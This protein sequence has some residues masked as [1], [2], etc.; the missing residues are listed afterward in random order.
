M[1]K[2]LSIIIPAYNEEKTIERIVQKVLTAPIPESLI[3][4]IIIVNDGSTDNTLLILKQC[5]NHPSIKV[6]S[7][8][9]GG[10][11]SALK[12][13]LKEARGDIILIQDA[14]LEYDPM[15]YPHLVAPILNG[16]SHVVYGSRFL[17]KI[18]D[19]HWVNRA[20]N[21]VSNWTMLVMW[22]TKITDIN[23][24][25]KVF[26]KEALAG[27]DIKSQN[28]AFETEITTKF[29]KKGLKVLEVPIAYQA[30]SRQEGKKIKWSTA[31]EMYWPIISHRFINSIMVT[32][33]ACLLCSN[34]AHAF[35]F[36]KDQIK[37]FIDTTISSGV[38]LRLEKPRAYLI[39]RANGGSAYTVDSDDGDRHYKKNKLFSVTSKITN[40]IGVNYQNFGAFIRTNF[41]FDPINRYKKSLTPY[42]RLE[43]GQGFDLL[44]AYVE[45]KF[46]PANKALD[47]RLGNQV[48]NWG[49]SFFIPGGLNAINAVD[50]SKLRLPGAEVREALLPSPMISDSYQLTDN[51]SISNFYIF[52]FDRTK[53]DVCGTYFAT[54]DVFCEG[55]SGDSYGGF[56][57]LPE[58]TAGQIIH[59]LPDQRPSNQGQFGTAFR[60]LSP[61]LNDTEF[62]FYFMNYHNHVPVVSAVAGAPGDLPALVAQYIENLQVYG[63]SA[64]TDL[65]GVALQGEY[66]YRP[67]YPMQIDGGEFVAAAQYFPSAQVAAARAPGDIIRGWREMPVNQLQASVTKAFGRDNPFSAQ[68]WLVAGEAAGIYVGHFPDKKDLRFEAPNTD[69]S[70]YNGVGSPKLQTT[71]WADRFSW[72]YVLATSL[73]YEQVIK[74]VNLVPRLAFSHDVMGTTPSPLN[75]FVEDSKGMTMGLNVLYLHVWSV[76]MS[77]TNYFGAAARNALQDRDF[78]SLTVKHWF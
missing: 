9:N 10:K 67:R 33:L 4:E 43:A 28:F 68:E 25:Y 27:I 5:A 55:G 20:A 69:L 24:C 59:R 34:D 66:T 13:G 42:E 16:T 74:N 19:M 29:L 22:G 23:T 2:I 21:K 54:D 61:E 44:D 31:L 30:R 7:K 15:H 78:A 65:N 71:G 48:L 8:S 40:D 37:G 50:L 57:S 32:L 35:R 77:Y 46:T 17:G 58:G 60:Y 45:G 3:K 75:Q 73:T 1:N 47:V 70:A 63:V 51:F 56:G 36:E 39:G 52:K 76:D 18:D 38:G 49:E 64:S 41:F 11:A 26:T 14:D 72:G 6:F 62:G 12:H 53:L